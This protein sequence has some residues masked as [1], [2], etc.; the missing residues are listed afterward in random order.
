MTLYDV[1][2][3]GPIH[4]VLCLNLFVI[5]APD[6]YR[7]GY[8]QFA[9]ADRFPLHRHDPAVRPPPSTDAPPA[10]GRSVTTNPLSGT[11][12]DEALPSAA[13]APRRPT[14]SLDGCATPRDEPVSRAAPL[15]PCYI[16]KRTLAS[17]TS[18]SDHRCASMRRQ[19]CGRC[20]PSAGIAVGDAEIRHERA[21]TSV[22]RW[23]SRNPRRIAFP[24]SLI[25]STSQ[26]VD[27][28]LTQPSPRWLFVRAVS[29]RRASSRHDGGGRASPARRRAR[30]IIDYPSPRPAAI[31]PDAAAAR[32]GAAGE[33]KSPASRSVFVGDPFRGIDGKPLGC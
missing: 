11:Q 24:V 5:T 20:S 13:S 7:G 4:E 21:H 33:K 29:I 3:K 14:G 12:T 1:Q 23:L 8:G 10:R 19:R 31:W 25:G 18:A 9:I 22:P 28:R 32:T 17:D 16:D 27:P 2:K 6:P 26:A 30:V 15:F